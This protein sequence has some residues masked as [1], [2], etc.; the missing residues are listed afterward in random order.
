MYRAAALIAHWTS[1][2]RAGSGDVPD[3]SPASP[4]RRFLT[5]GHHSLPPVV[6]LPTLATICGRAPVPDARQMQLLQAP[7]VLAIDF[8]HAPAAREPP[9]PAVILRP[10]KSQAGDVANRRRVE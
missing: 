6:M 4:R 2:R 9:A 10:L 1:K 7:P 3:A 5:C 8:R